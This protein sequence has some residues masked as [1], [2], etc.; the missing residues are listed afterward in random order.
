MPR[1]NGVSARKKCSETQLMATVYIGMGSNLDEPVKQLCR[2][3]LSLDQIISSKR[4]ADSGLFSSKALTLPGDDRPQPDYVNAVVKM[5]TQ[6]D[7]R[8]L[9]DQLQALEAAQGRQRLERWGPRTLDLD[10]LLYDDGII[11]QADLTVP[12]PAM[13]QRNFVLY[14]LQQIDPDLHIPGQGDVSELIHQVSD[15]GITYLGTFEQAMKQYDY[16]HE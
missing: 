6:L 1:V 10:I 2:A 5:E 9:L 4:L 15:Q 3:L 13:A 14:P 7:P 12:H 16:S 11:S 8:A